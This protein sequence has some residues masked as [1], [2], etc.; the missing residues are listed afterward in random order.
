[1]GRKL[2][3][4]DKLTTLLAE[5]EA[6]LNTRPLT[7]V[8]EEFSS[9]FVLTPANF[10]IG[11]CNNIIPFSSDD[12]E[13][14]MEHL[15][16]VHSAKELLLYW[17]R[18]QKQLQLLWKY[19]TQDYLLNLRETLPLTHKGPKAQVKRQPKIGEIVIIKDSNL[20]RR[21]W[22]L[23]RINHIYL[24]RKTKSVLLKFSYLT[25]IF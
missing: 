19:W 18:N 22:K 23:G 14:E 11:D 1:M 20:P 12:I 24:A 7:Y 21:A 9:G 17:R 4:W 13:D 8:Y 3:Y 25:K 10:L 16:K 2:L 5:V 15:P 6:I